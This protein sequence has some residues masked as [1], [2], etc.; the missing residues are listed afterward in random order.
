MV[1]TWHPDVE[2]FLDLKKNHGDENK[3]ARDL[4]YGLWIP[5][6]FMKRVVNGE[7]WSLFCPNKCPGLQDSWGESF[8]AL[9]NKYESEGKAHAVIDA[10]ALWL[11]IC[12]STME[13]GTPYLMYK[14]SVNA[15]SNQQNLGTIRASNLC[16]EVCEYTSPEETAVCTLA[17]IALPKC[18]TGKRFDFSKLETVTRLATKNLNAVIDINYYPIPEAEY[19]NKR[20][21]PI[22]LG[23]QGL[24]DVF[25]IMNLPYDSKEAL[26]LNNEIFET[27]YYAA[28]SESVEL[29][30]LFGP[31]ET[32]H[33]SPASKGVL[34]FDMWGVKPKRYKWDKLKQNIMKYGMRN[35]L[36]V[37]PMPTASTAQI[38]GNTESFEP[39]T[40]NLYNRR[41]LAGEYMVI[42][43]YLQDKLYSLGLWNEERRKQLIAN[44]GSVQSMD[45]PDEIKQV[46]KTVWEMSQKALIQLAAGRS[47]FIC[48]SQSLNLYI[49]K[50]TRAILSSMGMYAWKMGLK[51]GQ[52]YLRSQPEARAIQFTVKK[53]GQ[54]MEIE[55][56]QACLMCSA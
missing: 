38:L 26:Q 56:D 39:R 21:R 17:S 35:S 15:K 11:A 50:P 42:N 34:Q 49:A 2:E 30:K 31:Y 23:I 24:A 36:L 45:V 8:E 40:T 4:F 47:A 41:V 51:T 19:S 27:I 5:D 16:C 25:Q 14:D 48:Q 6:L 18:M 46:Y 22:G 37:A 20:H 53:T 10:Q 1:R 52:Y 3:R 32:F 7:K 9:Y 12:D 33:G 13:T 54:A 28:V 29:S 55:D 43:P 44:R